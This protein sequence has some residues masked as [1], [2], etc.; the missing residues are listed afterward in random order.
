MVRPIAM[1]CATSK[2][3]YIIVFVN[4]ELFELAIY[5]IKKVIITIIVSNFRRICRCEFPY[6]YINLHIFLVYTGLLTKQIARVNTYVT[7]LEINFICKLQIYIR[8]KIY[9]YNRWFQNSLLIFLQYTLLR[10]IR[11]VTH[12]LFGFS[13]YYL[14]QF[15]YLN[16][17]KE[18]TIRKITKNE[19][20][21]SND[22]N[23]LL[24]VMCRHW[25]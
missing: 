1:N 5:T 9:T 20:R 17:D 14:H 16:V 2:K 8:V 18:T 24:F 15:I 13:F 22:W 3:F 19:K 7:T 6:I 25:N 12:F 4:N 10:M 21:K 23:Y 11:Y